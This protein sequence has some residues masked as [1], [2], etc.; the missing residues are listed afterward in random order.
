VYDR[1]DYSIINSGVIFLYLG[2]GAIFLKNCG[3][4]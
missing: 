2:V 3:L 1:L 4:T